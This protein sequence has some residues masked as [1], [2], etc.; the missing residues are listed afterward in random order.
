MLKAQLI[1]SALARQAE[2]GAWYHGEWTDLYECHY[3]FHAG[4]M[5]LL[6]SALIEDDDPAGATGK[7]TIPKGFFQVGDGMVPGTV[8]GAYLFNAQFLQ[9]GS[10]FFQGFVCLSHQVQSPDHRRDLYTG[11][12][13]SRFYHFYYPGMT[14]ARYKDRTFLHF[15]Y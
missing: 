11:K 13:F 14:A 2:D 4:G 3:R 5:Q 7:V 1:V 8:G 10:N 15:D 9:G 6:E 12:F